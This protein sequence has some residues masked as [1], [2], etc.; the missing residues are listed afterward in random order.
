M[1][2]ERDAADCERVLRMDDDD[3]DDDDDGVRQV[4]RCD[5]HSTVVLLGE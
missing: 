1:K 3:D 2:I 5:V 4:L